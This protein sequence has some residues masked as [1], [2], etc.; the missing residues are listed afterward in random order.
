[1]IDDKGPTERTFLRRWSQRKLAA[2]R[3]ASVAA[4]AAVPTPEPGA[5][6]SPMAPPAAAATP[7]APVELPSVDTL[8]FDSD[9]TAFLQPTVDPATKQAALRKLF[10]DPRFNVMDGL[11]V[12]IDDYNKFEPLPA[13]LVQQ[14]AHA[15]Y[16]FDP[17]KTR[18]NAAGHVEDVPPDE[19]AAVAASE[20]QP[21][22][23]DAAPDGADSA[24]VANV[25]GATN[26]TDA[27]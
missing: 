12:Y 27:A 6:P 1:M 18:V 2:S 13:E 23:E 16:L 8:S 17:P 10:S 9:F 24:S 22:I 19:A 15:K 3:E 4:Q 21:A 5:P 14:L 25:P 26:K 11:D 20:S 7:Q